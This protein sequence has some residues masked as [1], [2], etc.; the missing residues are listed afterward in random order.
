LIAICGIA[1]ELLLW[2]F[3]HKRATSQALLADKLR[4]FCENASGVFPKLGQILST[5]ADLLPVEVCGRL[6]LLLDELPPLSN[7]QVRQIIKSNYATVPFQILDREP[8]ASASIAQVHLAIRVDDN[9][10]IA[11]KIIRPGIRRKLE[12]DCG[13]AQFLA[14]FAARLP[15]L[16]SI[17][18]KEA[19][20]ETSQILRGQAE[21]AQ[22]AV[23]LTRLHRLFRNHGSIVVPAPHH[24]ISTD[25]ILCMDYVSGLKKLTDPR[26][27]DQ[28]AKEAITIGSCALFEMIFVAGFVHCDLH[29]GNIMVDQKGRVVLLDAG[30]M[31]VLDEATRRAFAMFFLAIAMKDGLA[32]S[33]IVRETATCLPTG[34]DCGAFDRDICELVA[35]VGG[36]KAR[37]FQIADFV[38]ELFAIQRKRGIRG[39]SKFTMTILSL[40]VYEGLAK[41]RFPELDFQ[42]KAIPFLMA[43]LRP[44]NQAHAHVAAK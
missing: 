15:V 1:W 13:I 20:A 44:A 18:V 10:P 37:D 19:L 29:P 22:E 43:A 5:R 11:V 33:R 12:T 41:Q 25:D 27:S 16:S 28:E 4:L 31:T 42:Q 17:P 40:L 6:A 30:F 39:T 38:R 14:T 34:L 7:R 2:N 8:I 36:L 35:R 23:N 32:A 24:D 9:R 3:N 21:F 26:L